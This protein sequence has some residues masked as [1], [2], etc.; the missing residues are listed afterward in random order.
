MIGPNYW[1]EREFYPSRRARMKATTRSEGLLRRRLTFSRAK[2]GSRLH[3][4]QRMKDEGMACG[5][6]C[7][8]SAAKKPAGQRPA[9][10]AFNAKDAKVRKGKQKQEKHDW[11]SAF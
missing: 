9:T 6:I 3:R 5:G 7:V 1:S 11:A 2:L 8:P 10:R 4:R